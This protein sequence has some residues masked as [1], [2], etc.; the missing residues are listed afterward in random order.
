[1]SKGILRPFLIEAFISLLVISC[2][3]VT[4]RGPD[5]K[6]PLAW[7]DVEQS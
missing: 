1:M 6:S 2:C 5:I 4:S 3:Y 7:D